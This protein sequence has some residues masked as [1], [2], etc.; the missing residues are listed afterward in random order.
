[1]DCW[2][3]QRPASPLST[4]SFR[5]KSS[6]TILSSNAMP[7]AWAGRSLG[8][9]I[10]RSHPSLRRARPRPSREDEDRWMREGGQGVRCKGRS[11]WRRKWPGG[12]CKTGSVCVHRKCCRA[13]E[14]EGAGSR[15]DARQCVA[16]CRGVLA[17]LYCSNVFVVNVFGRPLAALVVCYPRTNPFSFVKAGARHRRTCELSA[18]HCNTQRP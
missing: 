7:S 3:D 6:P 2:S 9:S 12:R 13:D 16:R 8:T 11:R 17:L 1:M 15:G 4:P 18:A 10:S 5:F 14:C